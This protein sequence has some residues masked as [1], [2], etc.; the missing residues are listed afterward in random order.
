M[1][2]YHRLSVELSLYPHVSLLNSDQSHAQGL[3][4]SHGPSLI[5]AEDWS[6]MV[7]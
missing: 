5:T 3:G 2:T 4:L 7:C 6:V 1:R